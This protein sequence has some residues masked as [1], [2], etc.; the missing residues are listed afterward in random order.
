MRSGLAQRHWLLGSS[1]WASWLLTWTLNSS[2]Q[3]CSWLLA[4]A[5][6]ETQTQ[7]FSVLTWLLLNDLWNLWGSVS[8]EWQ[9]QMNGQS[10]WVWGQPYGL[11]ADFQWVSQ[12]TSSSYTE[13][14][15]WSPTGW[16]QVPAPCF[17]Y[18][19]KSFINFVSTNSQPTSWVG[20]V[21][22]H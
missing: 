6:Q 1:P 17:G 9:T 11:S 12:T 3:I 4:Q 13:P 16:V 10:C 5:F 21:I 8:S 14:E 18:N 22:I 2:P 19:T 15:H 7:T 20:T